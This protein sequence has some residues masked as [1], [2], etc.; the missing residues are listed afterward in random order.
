MQLTFSATATRSHFQGAVLSGLIGVLV[1]FHSTAHG[2][3]PFVRGDVDANGRREVTDSIQIFDFLFLGGARPGCLDAADANNDGEVDLSDTSWLLSFLFQGDAPPAQPFPQCGFD[4]DLNSLGCEKFTFS[5]AAEVGGRVVDNEG[6]GIDDASVHIE[7]G[8]DP[9]VSTSTDGHFLVSLHDLPDRL[10]FTAKADGFTVNHGKLS[11]A[12][13]QNRYSVSLTLLSFG[14]TVIDDNPEDGVS[15]EVIEDGEVRGR[16]VIPEGAIP[17]DQPVK[18][19]M[20]VLDP[21]GKES[22]GTPGGDLLAAVEPNEENGGSDTSHLES[23]GMVEVRITNLETEEYIGELD[24]PAI[25]EQRLPSLYADAFQSGDS[26][27]FLVLRRNDRSVGP[28]GRRAGLSGHGR[29]SLVAR[30][31]EPLQLAQL[32]PHPRPC[33][34]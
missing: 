13:N 19:E 3:R 4:T 10:L 15:A 11:F 8:D 16:L 27:P 14:T 30:R 31:G 2:V 5:P 22:S 34:Y 26:I 21:T 6:N 1:L 25:L 9:P 12:E 18:V 17:T 32:G 33:L 20:T 29:F 23:L 24:V 28:R 7:N